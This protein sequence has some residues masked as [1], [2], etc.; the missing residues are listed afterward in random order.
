L[1][2]SYDNEI[3]LYDVSKFGVMYPTFVH[4]K[5]SEVQTD[6]EEIIHLH[7]LSYDKVEGITL[8]LFISGIHYIDADML[9]VCFLDPQM[10]IV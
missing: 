9:I 3:L 6:A 8:T 5:L 7:R 1:A 2:I 10:G 4:G